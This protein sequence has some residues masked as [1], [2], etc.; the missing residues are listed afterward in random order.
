MVTLP[1]LH[2]AHNLRFPT[3]SM[4]NGADC[5]QNAHLKKFLTRLTRSASSSNAYFRSSHDG[6]RAQVRLP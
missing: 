4:T 1:V 2:A 5:A 3:D 6:E